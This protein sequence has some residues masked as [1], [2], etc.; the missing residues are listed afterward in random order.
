[1]KACVRFP[2][3]THGDMFGVLF[4]QFLERS[5]SLHRFTW[6]KVTRCLPPGSLVWRWRISGLSMSV[7]W[8]MDGF[9]DFQGTN[10]KLICSIWMYL[11]AVRWGINLT[12]TGDLLYLQHFVP[13]E[14]CCLGTSEPVKVWGNTQIQGIYKHATW[15]KY[16]KESLL[17]THTYVTC[18]Y[19]HW[20]V[21][22]FP[23]AVQLKN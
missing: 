17:Y 18:V 19:S 3:H 23:F 16:M 5:S 10:E 4:W 8:K 1:M 15:K 20:A 12:E 21:T 7:G 11:E 2:N 14:G 13:G 22:F 6:W 9:L